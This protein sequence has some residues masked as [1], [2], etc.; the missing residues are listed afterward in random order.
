MPRWRTSDTLSCV[1]LAT[2][3]AFSGPGLAQAQSSAAG[4]GSLALDEVIVTARKTS[5][6][7]LD[8]PLSISAFTAE[9]IDE[10]GFKT[11]EDVTKFAPGVQYSQMGGQIPGRFTS[12][13]RFRGMNVNSDSPSLQL[14]AL[15]IDGIYALGGTQS[16]PLDDIERI[17]VIKG[18]QS[19]TYGRSTFGGAI[20]YITRTPSLTEYG[21]QINALGANYGESDI[22]GSFEGPIVGD[23]VSFRVGG[24]YYSRGALFRASDGGGLGEEQSKSAHLTLYAAPTDAWTMK[25]RAFY[26]EDE[27]GPTHGGIV[28][29]VNNDSCTGKT[30][31]TED[32]AVPIASPTR[33]ICGTVPGQ[34]SAI[35]ATGGT[36][37]IDTVT[38]LFAPLAAIGPNPDPDYLVTNLA[39]LAQPASLDVPAID[40]VG[41]IRNVTRLS[42]NSEYAFDSGYEL[43]F[44]AGYNQLKA[45]WIRSFGLTP[46]GVW[47]S[48]DPQDSEDKSVELRFT[49]PQ[50]QR[51]SWLVGANYYEQEFVQSGSGGDA[52]WLCTSFDAMRPFG[53]PCSGVRTL[54]P[55]NLLQNTDKVET[56][57]LFA[58]LNFD[59]TDTLSAS[60]EGRWQ[61]DT[62]KSAILTPNPTE[63]EDQSFLPRA[64]LRW[65]PTRDTNVYGSY[66][67]GILPGTVNSG[68]ASATPSEL[69]QYQAQF[70]GI[71]DVVA[72]DEL[73]M[74]EIG[75]KQQ[76][77]E[78]RAQTE[79]AAYYGE[80]ENQKGRSVFI[81][82]ETCGSPQHGPGGLECINGPGSQA[83]TPNSRN[84]NVPGNSK[85]W[86]LEATGSLLITERWDARATFTWAKSEYTDFLFN[87]VAPIAGFS[88]QKG[89]SN[90]RFPEYSGS[91][92][93]GYSAPINNS[94][95]SWFANGDLAYV[96]EAFVDE[97]NLANCDAYTVGNVRLGGERDGLRIEG[98]VK[99]VFDDDS[100]T[101]CARWS[102]FDSAPNIFALTNFQGVAVQAQVPR[103]YGLRVSIR[104]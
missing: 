39:N 1:A 41:L 71:A 2:L 15:F 82:F 11:L 33:F 59:F 85:L 99:N 16:I 30:I 58:S 29:G 90:A 45:N 6:R 88:Q 76:W 46:L 68:I 80:W 75:W 5:E 87:F 62:T 63:I 81:I 52:V 70:A 36:N 22:S 20:N 79:L 27:D 74:F 104:F 94:E 4:S 72:G 38:S 61:D 91:L 51:L 37:I 60:L 9:D 23:K 42:F 102:D 97:S 19:A 53:A 44:Q 103:Q 64:I 43:A 101:A 86:G 67:K 12:A 17:E 28:Q 95:W 3:A 7:L 93:T 78:G 48:R 65:Q 66:A 25:F 84:A 83:L 13:I 26:N 47:W 92:Y 100:W 34:G 40:H 24:R 98:F 31:E 57:G 35:S 50:D 18:P 32:P 10:R 54:F 69:A 21:G 96:G 8:A 77:A 14:G 55:N 89:N 73:D 49:S 56:L